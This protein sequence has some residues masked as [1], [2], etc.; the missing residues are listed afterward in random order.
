MLEGVDIKERSMVTL[1]KSIQYKEDSQ[2]H[3]TLIQKDQE[4]GGDG[5]KKVWV[6]GTAGSRN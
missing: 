3:C 2:V 5:I 6:F 4:T 1:S